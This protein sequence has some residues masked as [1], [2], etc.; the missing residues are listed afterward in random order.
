MYNE[1]YA[2]KLDKELLKGTTETVVLAALAVE[3]SHGYRLVRLLQRRSEGIFELGEG[4]LYPLLYKLEAKGWIKGEWEAGDGRRRRRVYRVTGRG[5]RQ[6]A[7]RTEEWA[8]LAR[9]MTLILGGPAH[10]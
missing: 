1:V 4:T 2:V 8:G 6:L 10:A 3:P 9:G 5:R 7:K